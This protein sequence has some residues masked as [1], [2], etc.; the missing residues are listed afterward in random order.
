MKS[1][2]LIA[3]TA[4]IRFIVVKLQRLAVSGKRRSRSQNIRN[5]N[6]AV[7]ILAER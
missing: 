6:L 5:G 4:M 2:P 1:E 3:A 7:T